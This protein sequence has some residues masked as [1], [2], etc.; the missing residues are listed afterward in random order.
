MKT[1]VFAL[2]LGLAMSGYAVAADQNDAVAQQPEQKAEQKVAMQEDHA[3]DMNQP[4]A[5]DEFASLLEELEKQDQD[6]E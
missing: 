4:D 2:M 6:E 1:L 3:I 5:K